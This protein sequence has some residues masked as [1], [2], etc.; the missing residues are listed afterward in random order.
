MLRIFFLLPMLFTLFGNGR[1]V[2]CFVRDRLNNLEQVD[3]SSKILLEGGE[4][5]VDEPNL[6]EYLRRL[7]KLGVNFDI[8]ANTTDLEK[9]NK[10]FIFCEEYNYKECTQQDP[11]LCTI[12]KKC[13]PDVTTHHLGCMAVLV[14]N[15]L[16]NGTIQQEQQPTI[17]GCWSQEESEMRECLSDTECIVDTRRTGSLGR[18][19]K[20]CC[21][22]THGC[23]GR[24]STQ[25]VTEEPTPVTDAPITGTAM[26]VENYWFIALSALFLL[27]LAATFFVACFV[28]TQA[29]RRKFAKKG[30]KQIQSVNNR[31]PEDPLLSEVTLN[32]GSRVK[33]AEIQLVEKISDGRFGQVYRARVGEM[34]FAVKQFPEKEE[35]SWTNEMDLYN[36]KPL[37]KNDCIAKFLGGF[38]WDK[39]CWL[40]IKFYEKASLFDFLKSNT[41]SLAEAVKMISTMLNGLAFLHEEIPSSSPDEKPTIVH[42]DLKSKNILVQDDLSTCITDFGLALRCDSKGISADQNHLQVHFAP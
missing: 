40:L 7:G 22:K 31:Q 20:F 11:E 24:F 39:K 30:I 33:L 3:E 26:P 5:E 35:D 4:A 13:Y 12:I 2:L 19:A 10:P 14:Y 37:C 16:E 36:L 42:R 15:T 17:K 28:L 29:L 8:D 9:M 23:N 6:P 21:C 27:F 1:V 41:I 18:N 32:D 25:I 38:Q 34:F